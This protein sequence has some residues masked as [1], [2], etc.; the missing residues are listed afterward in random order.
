MSTLGTEL[1]INVHVDPIDG[2]HMSDYDFV[3]AFFTFKN[4]LVVIPKSK[5]TRVDDDNYIAI[6]DTARTG[7][8][9]LKLRFEADIPDTDCDDGIRKE[10]SVVDLNIPIL[11]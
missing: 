10:I 4:R 11:P 7:L 5:M 3:C 8:G 2:L 6:V 1:K 9:G